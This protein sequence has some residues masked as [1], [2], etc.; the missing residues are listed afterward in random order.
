[1]GVGGQ[2]RGRSQEISLPKLECV[3]VSTLPADCRQQEDDEL[4]L[5][6]KHGGDSFWHAMSLTLFKVKRKEAFTSFN[7]D[8]CCVRNYSP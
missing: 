8:L 7:S 6:A 1:M 2:M 5:E 3:L 4:S